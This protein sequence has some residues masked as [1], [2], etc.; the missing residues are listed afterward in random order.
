MGV[1]GDG[2]FDGDGQCDFLGDVIDRLQEVVEE[3]LELGRS[4]RRTRYRRANLVKGTSIGLHEPVVPAVAVLH[5]IFAEIPRRP[6][7]PE[8][9]A[10]AS[11]EAGVLRVVREGVR[12]GQRAVYPLP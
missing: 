10:G 8:Q 11:V 3:G 9:E 7:V 5:A 12:P 6:R 2:V 4:K 1:W